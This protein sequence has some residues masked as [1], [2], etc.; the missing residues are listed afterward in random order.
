MNQFSEEDIRKHCPHCDPQSFALAN[1]L[2]STKNFWVVCDV[3]PL[4]EGHILIIP[5]QHLSCVGEYPLIL[6]KD[7]LKQYRR[8]SEFLLQ[9]YGSVASFEHGV[10][11]QTVFHSHLHLFPFAGKPEDIVSEALRHIMPISN[12][13]ALRVAFQ[14]D[15]KYLFFSIGKQMWLV[16]T[17][18]GTP[19]FF[20]DRFAH[21]LG[22]PQRGN[23]RSMRADERVMVEIKKDIQ[24]LKLRWKSYG[25]KDAG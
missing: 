22:V 9:S 3:H 8:V 13:S 10:I 5:K 2:Q 20:R 15:G 11:G 18:L 17:I 14:R 24:N 6:F 1:K 12:L 25:T 4:R 7:F 16:D 21:A 19:R 23:W